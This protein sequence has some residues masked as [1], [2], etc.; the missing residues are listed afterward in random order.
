MILEVKNLSVE[1]EGKKIL[2]DFNLKLEKG[3]VYALMGQNGS[4]KST[5]ANVLAGNPKYKISS[6]KIF[7]D[8]EDITELPPDEKARRG[9]FMSF[10]LPSE[11]P[12]V[13][14]YDFLRTAYN[15]VNEKKISMQE[16]DRL[17]EEKC[18]L[19]GLDEEFVLRYL[20]QGF[21]GGEKK[22]SEILQLLILN[23]KI[24]ILDETDS[25][26]DIDALRIISE[27]VNL[28]DKTDKIIL[29]ISHYKRIF[30][31][32]S[33]DKVFIMSKGKIRLEGQKD[34]IDELEDKGYSILKKI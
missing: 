9:I 15:S 33:P 5:L 20:N 12:G 14:I 34:L 16:Y 6:G 8:G 29:I 10:Q 31:L 21:S 18:K 11:I 26:L 3:N 25:G 23:P 32:I 4:G 22:K 27:S 2:D 30:N 7:L 17:L 13:A 19:L 1:I 28:L 24:I